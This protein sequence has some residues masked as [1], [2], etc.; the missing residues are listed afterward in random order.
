MA[1]NN[2]ININQRD[3]S[4][5]AVLLKKEFQKEAKKEAM[6]IIPI[7][8]DLPNEDLKYL[9][10][11]IEYLVKTCEDRNATESYNC[12]DLRCYKKILGELREYIK[13]HE[14]YSIG[15]NL[16]YEIVMKNAEEKLKHTLYGLIATICPRAV[17]YLYMAATL[18]MID[19]KHGRGVD[20][21]LLYRL[22]YPP[23]KSS[24]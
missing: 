6:E 17:H 19:R 22:I 10:D 13:A 15:G 21:D 16:V 4:L 14:W 5:D 11:F 20:L 12:K 2:Q 18:L 8:R 1:V 9:A 24:E 3:K 23:S 7:L